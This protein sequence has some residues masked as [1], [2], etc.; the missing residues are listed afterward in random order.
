MIDLALVHCGHWIEDAMYFEFQYWGQPQ[1]LGKR[2]LCR[3]LGHERKRLG[4]P[5]DREW[6][7]LADAYR[8]LLA[9]SAPSMIQTHGDSTHLETAL[10]YLEQALA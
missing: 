3:Q 4:L 9:M 10:N 1:R 7:K 6:S 2:K 8:A 5:L